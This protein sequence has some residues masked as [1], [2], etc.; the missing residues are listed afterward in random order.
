MKNLITTLILTIMM[1]F[2]VM[3]QSKDKILVHFKTKETIFQ[4]YSLLN[5]KFEKTDGDYKVREMYFYFNNSSIRFVY[6]GEAYD[7]EKV[8]FGDGNVQLYS[9]G[10]KFLVNWTYVEIYS[11]Y[12][13]SQERYMK[14]VSSV[15]R[16]TDTYY[17][18]EAK[19]KFNKI[20]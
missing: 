17:D 10:Y 12:N 16:H 7:I 6:G 18:D 5:Q 8:E 11:D 4:K 2:G 14:V 1:S 19:Y 15:I 20:K 13:Y 9:G 3:A